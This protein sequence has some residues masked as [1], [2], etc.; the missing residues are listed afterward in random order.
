MG[1]ILELKRSCCF[2]SGNEFAPT[3]ITVLVMAVA[4]ASIDRIWIDARVAIE[5]VCWNTDCFCETDGNGSARAGRFY[6]SVFS[7]VAEALAEE[8]VLRTTSESGDSPET[9]PPTP[10][11]LE[12]NESSHAV[13]FYSED[14]FLLSGSAS[15]LKTALAA[16][17]VAL[18]LATPEHIAALQQRITA[19]GVDVAAAASHGR[20][21]AVDA[22]EALRA[23]MVD[24]WP[25]AERFAKTIGGHIAQARAS[26][27]K[28]A[29]IA[30]FGEMVAIL[31]T[32]G[33]LAA[34]AR[35]E[36]LWNELSQTCDFSLLCAYPMGVFDRSE[37]AESF[38]HI[39][40]AHTAVAP[41]E[42]RSALPADGDR[43]GNTAYPQQRDQALGPEAVRRVTQEKFR[44][45]I[46]SVQDYAIFLLDTNGYVISWNSGAQR[47]KGYTADE[48]IGRHFSC[49]YPEEARLSGQP[50]RSLATAAAQGRFEDEGWRVRKDGTRFW[51][52][53]V[54]T[55]S[56]DANG[57]LT[58]FTKITR[59][60]TQRTL[61]DQALARA[62]EELRHEVAARI[63]AERQLHASEE[64]LRRLSAHLLRTQEDERRRL[65]RDLHD[66]V[67]QYLAVMKMTLESLPLG[68]A[69]GDEY[70][71]QVR[72]CV[73][74]VEESIKEVRTMSYL[75]YPPMLDEMGLKSAVPRF[76]DGF[77]KRSGIQTTF[78]M[79][80]DSARLAHDIEIAIFR[81]LQESLTNV[82]R[83]SG[84]TTAE[85]RITV[86]DSTVR[87]EVRDHGRGMQP[88]VAESIRDSWG[89]LGVGLRGMNERMR[90]LG[91]TLEI[92][93]S[94][95]GTVV[96]AAAPHTAL[97][98]TQ[99][100][101]GVS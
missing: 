30:A 95:D 84:S 6:P 55:P 76:L 77:A 39:C 54:I 27:G 13:Q 62:N 61:R 85:V 78:E 44:R 18:V 15:F 26:A 33:K 36:E 19:D 46:E 82:H 14:G 34:A 92:S 9:V 35:L 43:S 59:D 75:L 86:D 37:H 93:S 23:F 91:G 58:G 90:Q 97:G 69:S 21:H 16:G 38:R 22:H 1:A 32:E 2:I 68:P 20:F 72:E 96:I 99:P 100:A 65:G 7:L 60:T 51:A 4:H 40:A 5:N 80:R 81:V 50:H 11:W 70:E 74:L 87:L 73:G 24:G 10:R 89:T 64:S 57:E 31:C 29:R 71:A 47:I 53:V 79:P 67:G 88:E 3:A 12:R 63:S 17:N 49:F 94:S 101:S 8:L 66:N 56:R 83:H 52:S 42:N 25:D 48:I 45:D 28:D 41:A 98:R